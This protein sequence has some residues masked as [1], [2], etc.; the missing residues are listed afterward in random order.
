M[1]AGLF[2]KGDG[3]LTV[4]YGDTEYAA[5]KTIDNGTTTAIEL[6]QLN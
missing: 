3:G 5:L 1:D 4:G 2:V 6:K